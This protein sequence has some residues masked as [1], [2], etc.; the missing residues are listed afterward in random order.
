MEPIDFFRNTHSVAQKQYEALRMFFYE[1]IPAKVVAEK[2]GYTYR[3]FT[4]IVYNFRR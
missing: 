1:N 2:L 3:G 4:T